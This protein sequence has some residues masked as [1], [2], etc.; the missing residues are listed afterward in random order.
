MTC[1]KQQLPPDFVVGEC[2]AD[3][4]AVGWVSWPNIFC[5]PLVASAFCG[6]DRALDHP[7]RSGSDPALCLRRQLP[8]NLVVG[9]CMTD[10]GAVARVS[11]GERPLSPLEHHLLWE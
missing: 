2:M 3:P 7:C 5:R 11:G 6:S 4:R 9:E 8:P 10:A 1:C